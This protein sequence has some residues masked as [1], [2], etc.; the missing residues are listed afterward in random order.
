MVQAPLIEGIPDALNPPL[1]LLALGA[2]L[3]DDSV[4]VCVVDLNLT[5]FTDPASIEPDVFYEYAVERIAATRPDLVGFTSMM[6]ESHVCLELARLLK[7]RDPG[8]RTVFGG[9]HFGA[10]AT[11]M[12]AAYDWVDFVVAGEGEKAA[13]ELTRHLRG[14]R[15][16]DG[17]QN[18]AYRT[19]S[20]VVLD[21][22]YGTN[23]PF[24]DL[25]KP[26]HGLVD[27][28]EY[29]AVN[30]LKLLCIEH[31]RGCQLRCAFCYSEAHWGHGETTRAID[32]VVEDL[33]DLADLGAAHAFFVGDNFLTNKKQAIELCGA[34][35]QAR[36]PVRWKSYATLAQLS[37]PVVEALS[38]A[39]CRSVFIGVDAA[40]ESAKVAFRKTYFK[41]WEPLERTLRTC[42][43]NDVHP[44]CAFMLSSGD[45]AEGIEQTLRVAACAQA[46]GAHIC[47]NAL[48]VYNS[49]ALDHEVGSQDAKYSE[50]K[51]RL[52]CQT[53]TINT[54]NSL[55]VVRPDLFPLHQATPDSAFTPDLFALCH[56]AEEMLYLC[57][58]TLA[59]MAL[60]E[61]DSL[62]SLFNRVVVASSKAGNPVT[63]AK[64]LRD[65]V[66]VIAMRA[67]E[68]S[69]LSGLLILD[70]MQAAEPARPER[71]TINIDGSTRH[72]DIYVANTARL[73]VSGPDST[74]VEPVVNEPDWRDFL[75]TR[76]GYEVRLE[77]YVETMQSIRPFVE[78]WG[79]RRQIDDICFHDYQLLKECGVLAPAALDLEPL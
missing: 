45:T 75:V 68:S 18:V 56:V 24:A 63:S 30:T 77:P 40:S 52:L 26:A 64:L 61:P 70:L 32:R 34:I 39:G 3:L 7:L 73:P 54:T 23:Y 25:P 58:S 20:G 9:P 53:S 55:A 31:A 35:E 43:D 48:A 8:L 60:D 17:L 14:Q 21:R 11:E 67:T 69:R 72:C 15:A 28:G 65:A 51:S 50:G 49:S 41:G 29:F 71:V 42:I 38:R 74:V 47:L 16:L 36:I 6:L 37:P 62:L 33:A 2:V 1:G 78:H 46:I 27:L 22:Q 19:R 13:V 12:M 10:I 76:R 4:D 5:V 66:G 59:R 57:P 44:T 79:A